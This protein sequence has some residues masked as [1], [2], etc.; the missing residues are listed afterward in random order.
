MFNPRHPSVPRGHV[1][2]VTRSAVNAPRAW[3]GV[4]VRRTQIGQEAAIGAGGDLSPRAAIHRNH[5]GASAS[6]YLA[7]QRREHSHNSSD[8]V[9]A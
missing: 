6:R 8:Q 2:G 9:K 4:R 5:A 3:I 1:P 7:A